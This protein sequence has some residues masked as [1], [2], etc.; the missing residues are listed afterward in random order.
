[1]RLSKEEIRAL[2]AALDG[3][4]IEGVFLFGSRADDARRGGDIDLLLY[5]RAPAF[6][7]AHKVSSRFALA[8]DAKLDVLVV[9]P[10]RPTE[11][12]QAF[13]STLRP[14]PLDDVLRVRA[15]A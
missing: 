4:P 3:L 15:A 11:E 14:V 1:M 6:A 7:L 8:L 9:D 13:L 10:D 2:R 12:E 5:S